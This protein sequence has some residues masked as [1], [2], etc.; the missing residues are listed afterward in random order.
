MIRLGQAQQ[1]PSGY[2]D[3]QEVN[4][5]LG[6]LLKSIGTAAPTAGTWEKGDKVWNYAPT[7][8]GYIGWVCITAGT[9]GVWKG[10]GLIQA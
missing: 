10:F 5:K 2:V 1:I 9:P 4:N 6:S 8:G 3:T 7:A